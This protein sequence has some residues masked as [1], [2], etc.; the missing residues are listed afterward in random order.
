[1]SQEKEKAATKGWVIKPA[2]SEVTGS[3]YQTETW[4]RYKIMP[5]H[6]LMGGVMDTG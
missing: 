1:M 2:I 6:Y 3:L 4:A 5:E